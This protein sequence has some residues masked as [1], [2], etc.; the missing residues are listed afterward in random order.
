MNNLKLIITLMLCLL[1]IAC[2]GS[3][4]LRDI[5]PRLELT[6]LEIMGE[7]ARLSLRVQNP[8][9]ILI[10]GGQL[11][12]QLH[13]DEKL[14]AIYNGHP[15]IDIIANSAEEIRVDVR[16]LGLRTLENLLAMESRSDS[17]SWGIMGSLVLNQKIQPGFNIKGRLSPIP[18]TSN[19]F[20]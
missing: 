16:V 2:G 19:I 14:F 13:I 20:R 18:G 5:Q 3:R 10:T 7:R 4:E 9:D 12:F 8:N 15:M 11:E 1:M 17:M 6:Q